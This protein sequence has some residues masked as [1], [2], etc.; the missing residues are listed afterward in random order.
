MRCIPPRS[1]K[2]WDPH[3]KG[4]DLFLRIG[5]CGTFTWNEG[6]DWDLELLRGRIPCMSAFEK[7][8]THTDPGLAPVL[9]EL[10]RREPIFHT[11]EFGTS[12][13]DFEKATAP[14]YWEASA[15]GRRYSR[16]FILRELKKHPP[17][18]AASVGW[19][20]QDHALRQLG[21]D[22]FLM[23]Y[24]L[25]QLERVT[26]RATIWERTSEGWRILYHQGTLVAAEEDDAY[27]ESWIESPPWR[28]ARNEQG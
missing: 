27:P 14:E 28:E 23:T 6:G 19:Q 22:V 11:R 8:F 5:T 4:E 16:E 9:E 3:R 1:S 18:D 15:S 13:D 25:R 24:T 10:K 12:R 20:C 21:S 2:A 17:V 26:R 7:V